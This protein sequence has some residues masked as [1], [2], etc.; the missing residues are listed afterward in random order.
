MEVLVDPRSFLLETVARSEKPAVVL[1]VVH[2]DLESAL[3]QP[4]AQGGGRGVGPFGDEVERGVEAECHF[5]LGE[6]LALG[7]A[8]GPLHVMREDERELFSVRP[9]GPVR[10]GSR[11]GIVDRPDGGAGPPLPARQD[12][13]QAHAQAPGQERL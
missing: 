13:A 4:G 9:A 8:F 11:G 6:P 5:E 7:H 1:E 3:R 10:G 2:A 12:P